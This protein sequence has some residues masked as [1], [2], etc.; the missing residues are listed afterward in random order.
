MNLVDARPTSLF[1]RPY[2]EEDDC[3]QCGPFHGGP[4]QHLNQVHNTTGWWCDCN[5]ACTVIGSD[6]DMMPHAYPGYRCPRCCDVHP[7]IARQASQWEGDFD[8][9]DDDDEEPDTAFFDDPNETQ[10]DDI[11]V[12]NTDV[13]FTR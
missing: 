8:D 5:C 10:P 7:D 2:V 6:D 13:I 9:N 11:P 4:T 3:S 1:R 12:Y